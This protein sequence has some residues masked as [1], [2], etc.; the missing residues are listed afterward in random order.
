MADY[1][2]AEGY[3]DPTAFGA[4][5]AIEKEEKALRAFRPI[6]YICSPYAGDI[7]NSIRIYGNMLVKYAVFVG[8]MSFL[9]RI[10]AYMPDDRKH[11]VLRDWIELNEEV[12]AMNHIAPIMR[13]IEENISDAL[14]GFSFNVYTDREIPDI[15]F[16]FYVDESI[17]NYEE[18]KET[19]Y[20]QIS[21]YCAAHKIAELWNLNV[22]VYPLEKHPRQD[23][24]LI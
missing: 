16:V 17:T 13:R 3:A 19:M 18:L 15:E 20:I 14:L 22:A 4:F 21:T 10:L 9:E 7:E 8:N 5:C 23:L 12:H 6:V 2:N 11:N 24:W 1:K